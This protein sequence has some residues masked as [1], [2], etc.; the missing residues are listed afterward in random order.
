VTETLAPLNDLLQGQSKGKM[1]IE[2]TPRALRAFEAS[3]ESLARS[4]LLAH[5]RVNAELALFDA[6]ES[7]VGAALQQ[8]T[9]EHWEPLASR[10]SLSPA[11]AKYS[12]FDRE[13]LAIYY[14]D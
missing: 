3:K 13:L 5:P 1:P 8:R 6:S 4:A 9:A 10:R 14:S 11:E 2:W 7:S 12:A